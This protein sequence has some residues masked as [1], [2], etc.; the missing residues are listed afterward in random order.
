[1]P[2]S[3]FCFVGLGIAVLAGACPQPTGDEPTGPSVATGT[4]GRSSSSGGNG[5]SRSGGSGGSGTGGVAPSG[6]GGA[7]P[8][9]GSPGSTGGSGAGTAGAAGGPASGGAPGAGGSAGGAGSDAG[10]PADVANTVADSGSTPPAVEPN[11]PCP[12]CVRI[13]NG[14]DF[15]GWEAAP[16]T[17]TIVG[18]A[19]R[20]SGGS[21]RAAYTKDDYGNVRL[22]VTSRMAPQNGD[23]LGILFWGDRPADPMKPKID[24]AGWVQ[25]MPPFGGMWSYHPPM[26]HG[27]RGMKV[28]NNPVP[29]TQWHTS[30]ILLNLDK[31]TLRAAVNGVEITRYTHEWPTERVDPTKRIIKG[32]I[33]MMRHGGGGSEYKDVFVEVD[34]EDKLVT[35]K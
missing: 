5:G 19:M 29:G 22:I 15:T 24:N 27:L 3:K 31:G 35:V 25:W 34:P 30:E 14:K 20:G 17:W 23:H 2:V 8:S 7:S 4:G 1:M 11:A 12:R 32:P 10:A 26:H 18:G 9:G 6:T 33:G 16:S 21:S 28:G 13:F